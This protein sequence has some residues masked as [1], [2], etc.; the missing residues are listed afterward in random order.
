MGVQSDMEIIQ[1]VGIQ[2]KYLDTL[3]ISLQECHVAWLQMLQTV[4]T[5]QRKLFLQNIEKYIV[6]SSI[7]NYSICMYLQ[8]LDKVIAR[9]HDLD[10]VQ[11]CISILLWSTIHWYCKERNIFSQKAALDYLAAKIKVKPGRQKATKQHHDNTCVRSLPFPPSKPSRVDL[12]IFIY[13]LLCLYNIFGCLWLAWLASVVEQSFLLH[14]WGFERRRQQ[15]PM[16]LIHRQVR[17]VPFCRLH[18]MNC[19]KHPLRF[20]WALENE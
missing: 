16:D 11:Q 7:M 5:Q 1:M 12:F 2:R 3:M 6:L 20:R 18:S 8:H 10:I 15:D 13:I 9:H 17:N 14:S 4:N 19:T